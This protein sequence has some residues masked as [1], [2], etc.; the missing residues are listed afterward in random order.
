MEAEKKHQFK[1]FTYELDFNIENFDKIATEQLN[2]KLGEELDKIREEFPDI[3]YKLS[4][5]A[6]IVND[7]YHFIGVI[8]YW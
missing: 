8:E 2:K 1:T 7:K 4:P 5:S 3:Q 6:S